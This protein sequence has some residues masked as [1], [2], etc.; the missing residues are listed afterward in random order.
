MRGQKSTERVKGEVA[1]KIREIRQLSRRRKAA[2]R[3]ANDIAAM[4]QQIEALSEH[5]DNLTYRVIKIEEVLE[6]LAIAPRP[7]ARA[8]PLR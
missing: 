1:R 8:E 2:S 3:R 6:R 7:P 4:K 5:V